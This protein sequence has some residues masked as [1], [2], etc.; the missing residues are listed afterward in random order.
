MIALAILKFSVVSV[1][2]YLNGCGRN[3]CSDYL[4]G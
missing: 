1:S 2:Q 3:E 4:Y